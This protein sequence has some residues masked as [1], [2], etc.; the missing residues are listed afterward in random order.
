MRA[1]RNQSAPSYDSESTEFMKARNGQETYAWNR[2]Y[3]KK[4]HK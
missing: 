1:T 4:M 2:D 3:I